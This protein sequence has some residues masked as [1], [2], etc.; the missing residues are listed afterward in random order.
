VLLL[1]ALAAGCYESSSGREDASNDPAPDPVPDRADST[2]D[3]IDEPSV[4]YQPE[5]YP[6][7]QESAGITVYYQI[8]SGPYPRPEYEYEADCTIASFRFNDEQTDISLDLD[9]MGPDG[10]L[11]RWA[12]SIHAGVGIPLYLVEGQEVVFRHPPSTHAMY[13]PVWFALYSSDGQLLVAGLAADSLAPP[14]Y[15]PSQWYMPLDVSEA[16]GLCALEPTSCFDAERIALDVSCDG[17]T[18]RIFDGNMGLVGMWQIYMVVVEEAMR[19]NDVRCPD[20]APKWFQAVIA[21][22]PSM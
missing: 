16:A 1:A 4:D 3:F 9:C 20:M 22:L 17:M 19:Y 10:S 14:G 18:T 6:D 8:E 11:D 13:F 7:C 21:A 15:V 5:V 12:I 2:P